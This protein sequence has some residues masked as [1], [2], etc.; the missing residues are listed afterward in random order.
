MS[1]IFALNWPSDLRPL[2]EFHQNQFTVRITGPVECVTTSVVM[3][4]NMVNELLAFRTGRARLPDLRLQVYI[5]ELDKLG[6]RGLSCRFPTSFPDI[7][8][9]LT[10]RKINPRGFMLPS[11]QARNALTRLASGLRQYYGASFK[12][13]QTSGNTLQDIANNLEAGNLVLVSG[14]LAPLGFEQGLL[15]GHPHTMGPVIQVDYITGTISSIDTG[16]EPIY[17]ARHENF[18]QFWGRKSRL[19]LY[20]RPYTLTVLIPDPFPA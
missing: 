10:T 7:P 3:A 2:S 5:D 16:A 9:P 11:S 12:F 19:N 6:W 18:M 1:S 15:G 13:R 4:R 17:T 14:L 20:T 8:V